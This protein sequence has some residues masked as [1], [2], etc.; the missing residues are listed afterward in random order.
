[1]YPI[2]FKPIYQ[3]YMWGGDRIE[4]LF[5]RKTDLPRVAESW[6]IS[7]RE[8]G[9][10]V[11][12]NGPLKG[13]TLHELVVEMGEDLMGVGQNYRRF[14]ILAKIIDAKENL[15]IQVHPDE[16]NSPS[17]H[18]EAK[19][20]MWVMLDDGSVYAGLKQPPDEKEFK[21]A[22]QENRAEQL[23]EKFDLKKGDVVNIPGGRVHA[24][25]AGSLIYE[26][27]Q[28]S[29][30]T[31]RLYDWGRPRELHLEEG[32]AAIRWDDKSSAKVSP[33]HLSS[34]LHHQWVILVE[35]P[36]FM[37]ERIDVFDQL[38]IAPIPKSF[39]IL[40][41]LDGE[42]E[43]GVDGNREPFHL[44]MTYL[45]PAACHSIDLKGPCQALRIRMPLG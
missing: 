8:E 9:M 18:G 30:T 26:V 1:M 33:R 37:V 40:Y 22:I 7:D 31:Y 5:H 16:A 17:L 4:R 11:V 27:Q 32:F 41:C 23:I 44:G 19:A 39:Q 45:I 2:R 13:K 35:T 24:I 14:P 25:C 21:K 38:H 10:S 28:N 42:G 3:T 20:E 29:N 15:S 34:D 12:M 43:V 6:E 36:Y